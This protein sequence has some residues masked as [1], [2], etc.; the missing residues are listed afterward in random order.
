MAKNNKTKLI[1]VGLTALVIVA[2]VIVSFVWAQADIQA[3]DVKAD[4]I[5]DAA[6]DLELEGCKPAQKNKFDVALMQKD[7][8]TIQKTQTDMRREQ[9]QGFKE[10]LNR[11]PK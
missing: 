2:G 1:G 3:V 7:I 4:N 6:D 8:S 9:K 10:I 11:L 5:I